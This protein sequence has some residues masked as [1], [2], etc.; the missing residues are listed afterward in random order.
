MVRAVQTK[1]CL[2]EQ[3]AVEPNLWM[4]GTMASKWGGA[5]DL[6]RGTARQQCRRDACASGPAR[7]ARRPRLV[8][9]HVIRFE[10]RLE[11]I[12]SFVDQD[13]D[14]LSER[15]GAAA[16]TVGSICRAEFASTPHAGVR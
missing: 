16:V 9:H 13:R 8:I 12:L 3:D 15:L 4:C 2:D 5:S 10:Q 7:S 14:N 1:E 11:F 6:R